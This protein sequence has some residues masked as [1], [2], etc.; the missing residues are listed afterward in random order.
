MITRANFGGRSAQVWY[1][2]ERVLRNADRVFL[3]G[4]SLPSDDVEVIYLLKRGLQHLVGSP[5]AI[6]VVLH[7]GKTG[8]IGSNEVG[9]RYRSIFGD[10]CDYQFSGFREWVEQWESNPL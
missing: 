9:L 5:G 4:Y 6:T 2:A 1:A 3:V 10:T 7:G 8:D